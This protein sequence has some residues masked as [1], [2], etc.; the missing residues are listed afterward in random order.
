MLS[1]FAG[2]EISGAGE[3]I[4]Q[5]GEEISGAGEGFSQAS[6]RALRG[7]KS[8]KKGEGVQACAGE[9]FSRIGG[10]VI[11]LYSPA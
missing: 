2:E 10:G 11:C 1:C 8:A 7:R 3:E 6:A 4:S 5:K 9:G